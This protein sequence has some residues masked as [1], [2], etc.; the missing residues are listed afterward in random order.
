M[1]LER[2][3]H[4]FEGVAHGMNTRDPAYTKRAIDALFD[5]WE[6]AGIPAPDRTPEVLKL[7]GG[8]IHLFPNYLMLPMYANSLAY[9]VRPHGDDPNWCKFEVWSLTTYPENDEPGRLELTGRYDKDD[10]EHWGLIPRQDF[11]NLERMQRGIRNRS[12]KQTTLSE[13][14]EVTIANMHQELDR[15]LA[16]R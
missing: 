6:G 8:D 13:Q 1:T 9:R 12:L 15:R 4:V 5:Y 10:D 14:W 7:W 3:I 16:A 11:A 2:D